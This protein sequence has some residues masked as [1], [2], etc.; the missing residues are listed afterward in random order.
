MKK[1]IIFVFLFIVSLIS[2]VLF[3]LAEKNSE[4]RMIAIQCSDLYLNVMML[5]AAGC[6]IHYFM[7][8]VIEHWKE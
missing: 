2:K 4:L 5:F 1:I 8:T 3:N 6:L 7:K